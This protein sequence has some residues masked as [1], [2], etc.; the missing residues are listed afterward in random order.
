MAGLR[1]PLPADPCS[2][3]RLTGKAATLPIPADVVLKTAKDYSIVGKSVPRLDSPAKVAGTAVY[4]IDFSLSKMKQAALVRCPV[5]G[6]KV[7]SYDDSQARKIDGV[8]F[9]GKIGESAVAIVADSVWQA[10]Q[11]RRALKVQWDEGQNK[12][13][14]SAAIY[15]S[16]KK[17]AAN[18]GTTLYSAGDVKRATGRR[19]EASYQLPFMAH[20]PMEP[21]NCAADFRGNSC[22]LWAPTQVPQDVRDS[23]AAALGLDP[24]Q[25]KVNVTLLGGGFGRR[26]EHDYGV[27]AAMVSKAAGVPVK[28]IWTRE[29]DMRFSTYRPAS[30][31]QL[32][33]T[34]DGAGWPSSFSHRIVSPSIS[35]Q[36]GTALNNGVDPDLP[37]EAS[38]VYSLPN[39]L[40]EYVNLDCAVPLGWM[41]SVYA[42]Q[43][44]FASESFID[45]LAV[46]A[47][48]DPLE[49][50]LHLLA[51]DEDIKYFDTIWK[52]ARMR[53]VLQIAA[54]KA[55]WGKPLPA[56]HFRG[57]ACFGCFSSYAADVVE[58]VMENNRPRVTRVIAVIDCGLVVNPNILEQQ[59]QGGV[60][61]A[62]TNALRGQITIE[63]GR[64]EQSNFD[65]YQ[66]L[67]M[68]EAPEVEAYFVP[69]SDTPTGAGEPVI[70]PVAPAFASAIFAATKKRLR[71]LP[72]SS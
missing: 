7:A 63:N 60:I 61:Y 45:E 66:P 71:S 47:G 59:I 25:V 2:Y 52:T 36:K 9:V 32:Q 15:D 64:V 46:A 48:K 55:G 18:K 30:Y 28:V 50:R 68:N 65:D 5:F 44:G 37:D 57:I 67:R 1:T 27:E 26:L 38:L 72:L 29:D 22:E 10:M 14:N 54:E 40:V 43:A 33:A 20:A 21:G 41:R 17:A 69:S 6:G 39:A 53:G 12:D 31:H 58:I 51:N 70:P 3:G 34:I 8:R 49:Y 42:L 19:I 11:A 13:L 56:G 23:V 24:D 16:L 35:G 62:L 4:G